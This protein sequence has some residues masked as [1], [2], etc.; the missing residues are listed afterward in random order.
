MNVKESDVRYQTLRIIYYAM[1]Y[2]Q[3]MIELLKIASE[4]DIT[5]IVRKVLMEKQRLEQNED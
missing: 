2:P 5:S 1:Q 3:A 4:Y